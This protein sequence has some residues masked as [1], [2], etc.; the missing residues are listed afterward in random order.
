M[1][2]TLKTKSLEVLTATL[3][4]EPNVN[5]Y[6]MNVEIDELGPA[7]I[8][9][10]SYNRDSVLINNIEISP[11]SQ[12]AENIV[13]KLMSLADSIEDFEKKYA[14]CEKELSFGKYKQVHKSG[15]KVYYKDGDLGEFGEPE[16]QPGDYTI[17]GFRILLSDEQKSEI[18]K[19]V[20]D[21]FRRFDN[22]IKSG[23]IKATFYESK[24][25]YWVK[26]FHFDGVDFKTEYQFKKAH[27]MQCLMSGS[28]DYDFIPAE[29]RKD[30]M[31]VTEFVVK[32]LSSFKSKEQILQEKFALAKETNKPVLISKH[33][34]PEEH[35]PLAKDEEGD[36]VDVCIYAMPDGT[37]ETT[38]THN[39]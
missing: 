22:D 19:I 38:Y 32:H 5:G 34:V 1:K 7:Q 17:Q 15:L 9:Y 8:S 26:G 12:T 11:Y 6:I 18:A 33:V 30:G 35:T 29:F 27:G 28:D 39:Y 20:K 2:L 31:D 4:L 36:M 24:S 13:R 14:L 21:Y 16:G 37:T 25:Q 23:V 3:S 10:A